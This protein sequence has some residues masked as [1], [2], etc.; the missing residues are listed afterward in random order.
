M[1]T[2]TVVDESQV[3]A[4]INAIKDRERDHLHEASIAQQVR[5]EKYRHK[6]SKDLR[7][8]LSDAGLDPEKIDKVLKDHQAELRHHLEKEKRGIAKQLL[9]Q[10]KLRQAGLDNTRRAIEAIA[11]KPHLVTLI[12]VPTPYLIAA[13][14]AGI[15]TDSHV[16]QWNNWG[17]TFFSLSQNTS[18]S[19]ARISFYFAWQNPSVYLA[20]INCAADLVAS[21]MCD[22][23]AIPGFF[24]GGHVSLNLRA[25]LTV[26][27]GATE[28]FWQQGQKVQ[29]ASL[30]ADGG[31][32]FGL[33]S[34]EPKIISETAH[35]NCTNI[36]VQGNQVVIF[37]VAF[38]AE[39][40]IDDGN[41]GLE[42]KSAEREILCPA[43]TV[44]L[45]TRPSG[46]TTP[47]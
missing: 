8:H 39:Y 3:K 35:L 27:I 24:S 16:E 38:V 2:R 32:I 23:N 29:I 46:G 28:I 10:E 33:G 40:S 19:T 22:L 1:A 43:L 6:L 12:P 9:E 26:F 41:I 30:S 13:T 17:K 20:V 14:P 4:I 15:L 42:F 18:S 5:L 34:V 31:G 7:R 44:E 11:F 47:P 21:G 36:E 25:E 45:L 37:E